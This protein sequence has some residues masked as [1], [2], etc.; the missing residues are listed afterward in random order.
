MF[1]DP[2]SGFGLNVVYNKIGRRIFQVGYEGY[3]SIYEAPRNLLDLQISKTI[4][5]SGEL[6]FSV[7]DVLNNVAIFYQDQDEDGKYVADKD[8]RISAI[9]T[10]T[11]YGLSFSYK[12]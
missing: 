8:S 10:G 4:F 6:K 3:K 7:N 2:L 11:N 9:T 1:N 5:K 12:F